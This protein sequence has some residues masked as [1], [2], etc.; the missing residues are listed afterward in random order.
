MPHCYAKE[1][2]C[3][4][5]GRQNLVV[6]PVERQLLLLLLGK[7]GQDGEFQVTDLISSDSHV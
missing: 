7:D 4:S 5:L 3:A 6:L 1:D 2:R